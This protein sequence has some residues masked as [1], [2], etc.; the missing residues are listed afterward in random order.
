MLFDSKS[1]CFLPEKAVFQK[2]RGTENIFFKTFKEECRKKYF[3]I[4]TRIKVDGVLM[5]KESDG[6]VVGYRDHSNTQCHVFF[7]SPNARQLRYI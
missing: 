2:D 3:I 6:K 7:R 1:F 4:L 5:L